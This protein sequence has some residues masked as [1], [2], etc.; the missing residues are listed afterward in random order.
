MK[1]N[2]YWQ[3]NQSQYPK[4]GAGESHVFKSCLIDQGS[5]G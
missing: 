2:Q 5:A 3:A 1:Q 4:Q